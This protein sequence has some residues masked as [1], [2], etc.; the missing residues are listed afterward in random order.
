MKFRFTNLTNMESR[1]YDE[2]N[3]KGGAK[4]GWEVVNSLYE[5]KKR[6]DA[7]DFWV[8]LKVVGLDFDIDMFKVTDFAAEVIA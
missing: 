3:I 7:C 8:M 6:E 2:R 1:E 5:L 4:T